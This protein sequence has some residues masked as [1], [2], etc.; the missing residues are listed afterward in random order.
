MGYRIVSPEIFPTCYN[1]ENN[2]NVGYNTG[3]PIGLTLD[4]LIYWRTVPNW[5]LGNV[6]VSTNIQGY[7][8][9]Y[10]TSVT[11]S[12]SNPII[13]SGYKSL[14]G[15]QISIPNE[16]YLLCV[17]VGELSG[18]ISNQDDNSGI[19]PD[20]QEFTLQAQ[21]GVNFSIE[22]GDLRY[23]NGLYYPKILV[24]AG[25][26]GGGNPGPP[27]GYDVKYSTQNFLSEDEYIPLT[28]FNKTEY[29]SG[30]VFICG[31]G[32][33]GFDVQEAYFNID[34]VEINPLSYW[35]FATTDGLDVYNTSSGSQIR[36]PFS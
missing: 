1:L 30:S 24:E 7:M 2:P 3:Y 33:G 8:S 32:C 36:D 14:I 4:E 29:I 16:G 6:Q 21:A 22:W 26:V 5:S 12:V 10:G 15:E 25:G 13:G 31:N 19:N 28:I 27:I 9:I 35:P 20:D 34:G 18:T 23:Y 17:L 11:A